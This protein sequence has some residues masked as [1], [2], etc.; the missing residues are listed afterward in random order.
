[1][2][3]PQ[4]KFKKI[5]TKL[6]CLCLVL[7]L[8]PLS[9]NGVISFVNSR[10]ALH[11][12]AG[13]SLSIL[14]Q[15]TIDKIDRLFFERE[16]D[17]QMCSLFGN[18][19]PQEVT[20]AANNFVKSYGFYD[21]MVVADADGKIIAANTISSEGKPINTS[22]LIGKSVRGE[23]WFD[24]C[25]SGAIKPGE[26]YS[27]D[28]EE[29]KMVHDLT[30]E[31]GLSVNFSAP[32]FDKNGKPIRVWSNRTSWTRTVGNMLQ[33]VK[34][35]IA[36]QGRTITL[37]VLSKNGILIYDEDEN[38]ILKVNYLEGKHRTP[39]S[40]N[41][42]AGETGYVQEISSSDGK[43][44]LYG[45]SHSKGALGFKGFGWGLMIKR[46]AE[47]AALQADKLRNTLIITTLISALLIAI[48]ARWIAT[49]FSKPIQQSV[50]VLEYLAKGDLTQRITVTSEDEI[51]RMATALNQ[52]MGNLTV[53]MQGIGKSVRT[54]ATSSEELSGISQTMGDDAEKT[55]TQATV[56]AA[57]C[58]QIS[59][60]VQTVAAGAE[61]M[62]S[63]IQEIAKN[64]SEA[65]AVALNA[66][67]ITSAAN[68][69]VSKLGASSVEIGEVIKVITSIAQQTNLLALNA[70]IEAARAGEAGK[71]F[72]VVANEV[73]ELAKATAKATED[74]GMKIETIQLDTK[75]AVATIGEISSTITHISDLQNSNAGAVEEQSATTNEM[76]RNVSEAATGSHEIAHNI[77]EVAQAATTTSR[78]ANYVL[79]SAQQ[80]GQL[81]VDLQGLIDRFKFALE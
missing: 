80:L 26:S 52:A 6:L 65:V 13:G 7:S 8:L 74:I 5:R 70:T 62:S 59:S 34:S 25:I 41:T 31:R 78:S 50:G 24:R 11:A 68:D 66:V 18:G 10:D 71:G 76:S 22:S 45:Y 16:G 67:K 48:I 56:V 49:T 42:V 73:K 1:M 33:Q 2:N 72:A 19:T 12:A 43:L 61:E 30:G 17:V 81:S 55:A 27:K 54:L 3:T 21:L 44:K 4:F 77:A 53:A 51:G 32:V 75:E 15:A 39:H 47:E 40:I 14:A 63:S 29:D 58:E 20:Q 57:A 46:P 23:E 36:S 28:L 79:K 60:N 9:I 69:T 38:K 64:S 37:Q 35:D